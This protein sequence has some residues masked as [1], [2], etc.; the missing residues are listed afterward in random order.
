MIV[1]QFEYAKFNDSIHFFCFRPEISSLAKFGPKHQNCSLNLKS[2]PW[3]I[4]I[5]MGFNG[6]VYFFRF[7]REILFFGKFDPKTQNSESRL[8]SGIYINS[9]MQNSMAVFC[10]L[11]QTKIP[12]FDKFHPEIQTIF[13]QNHPFQANLV[14]KIKIVCL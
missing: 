1:D 8:K 4:L 2:V 5:F 7:R 14:H 11:F 9:N 6:N 13:D 10:F 12:F 3:L